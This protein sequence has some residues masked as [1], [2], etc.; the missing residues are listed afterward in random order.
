MKN[1]ILFIALIAISFTACTSNSSIE[2]TYD[3]TVIDTTVI[4]Q[5]DSTA[6]QTPVSQDSLATTPNVLVP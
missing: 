2:S 6:I 5:N 3:S 1:T 4:P